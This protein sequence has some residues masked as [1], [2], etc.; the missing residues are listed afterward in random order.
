MNIRQRKTKDPC[1]V[2]FLHKDFCICDQIPKLSVK[3]RLS[4]VV[5]YK[6]LKRT[7][8]T[9][10][11]AVTALTNSELRIRG[12]EQE[13]ATDLSDLISSDYQ[14][15]FLYPSE[16]STLLTNDFVKN[17]TK[18]I[19]LIVPDGNWRQAGKVHIRHQELKSVPRVRVTTLNKATQFLRKEHV[20]G[21]MATLEAIAV[22]FGAIEGAEVERALTDLYQLKLQRTLQARGVR[23]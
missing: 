12:L 17:F 15:L 21:G 5:H 16:D 1:Q 10:R 7:S 9:G 23:S 20:E 18:P 8:N 22:A 19:R 4:L 3:T 2:C 11:L 13:E 6:E 14:S